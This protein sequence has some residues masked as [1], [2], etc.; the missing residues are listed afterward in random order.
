MKSDAEL[1]VERA[2][3]DHKDTRGWA[4]VAALAVI[5]DLGD[6]RG[7]K[8][9]LAEVDPS[10]LVDIIASL[11]DTIQC[12]YQ[13]QGTRTDS[14]WVAAQDDV[15]AR[16]RDIIE[17]CW[18][19]AVP[20]MNCRF[21]QDLQFDAF[22]RESLQEYI[23]DEF[24]I[25]MDTE[26]YNLCSVVGQVVSLVRLDLAAFERAAADEGI[27]PDAD[28]AVGSNAVED[29]VQIE[30]DHQRALRE[31]THRHYKGGLYKFVG[32][33]THSETQEEMVIYEHVWPHERKTWVRPQ[34]D[35]AAS[36][37]Q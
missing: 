37:A 1:N 18:G 26:A 30:L 14:T 19:Y 10:T 15:E 24:A 28:Y 8:H 23:E 9:A 11:E 22:D 12:A 3:A 4:H 29:A 21:V 32:L 6:R 20:N 5:E 36:E 31:A 34:R 25:V 16:I 7:I 27:D 17:R 33:A 13:K 2:L 35:S